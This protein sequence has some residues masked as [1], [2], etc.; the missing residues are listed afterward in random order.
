MQEIV[1][2]TF[3]KYAMPDLKQVYKCRA[4]KFKLCG[5]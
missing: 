1:M 5:H 4:D 2:F 3:N